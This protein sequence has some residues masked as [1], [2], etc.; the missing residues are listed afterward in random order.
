MCV[1]FAIGR[2][3]GR[4][5]SVTEREAIIE[6]A[7]AVRLLAWHVEQLQKDS[8]GKTEIRGVRDGMA[9]LQK[10]LGEKYKV[11]VC[12]EVTK[13]INGMCRVQDLKIQRI[14]RTGYNEVHITVTGIER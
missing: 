6:V 9:S 5:K 10:K 2:V 7:G 1:P 11:G 14:P 4:R 8:E 3:V 13:A 12:R